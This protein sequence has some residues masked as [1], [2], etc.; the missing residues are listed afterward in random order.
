MARQIIVPACF[1]NGFTPTQ[2]SWEVPFR[3]QCDVPPTIREVGIDRVLN[4]KVAGASVYLG[5]YGMGGAGLTGFGLEPKDDFPEDTLVLCIWGSDS[6]LHWDGKIIDDNKTFKSEVNNNTQHGSKNFLKE[7]IG[8]VLT[9]FDLHD[10]HCRLEF[11]DHVL[12]FQ[13]TPDN[14]PIKCGNKEQRIWDTKDS[15]W[16]AWFVTRSAALLV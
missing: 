11:D 7:V 3:D 6:W 15:L 1:P 4:R 9:S 5:T 14:R 12:E 8:T 13:E 16:D 10:N 2:V